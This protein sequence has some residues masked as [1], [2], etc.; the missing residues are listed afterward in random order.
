LLP[1]TQLFISVHNEALPVI[2]MSV[3]NEDCS[4]RWNQL[5]R[6]SPSAVRESNNH[7]TFKWFQFEKAQFRI[8][9]D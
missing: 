7:V 8:K 1:E 4:G 2:A 9:K 3:C 5:L 6:R